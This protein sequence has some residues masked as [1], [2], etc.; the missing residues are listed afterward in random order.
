M[1]R[2]LL[3]ASFNWT[4]IVDVLIPLAVMDVGEAVMVEVATLAAPGVKA[5]TSLSVMVTPPIVPV[6][7]EFPAVVEDVK[8]A[9]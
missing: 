3:L 6:T 8:V 5:T 1:V 2:L 7:V 9:V 4:V